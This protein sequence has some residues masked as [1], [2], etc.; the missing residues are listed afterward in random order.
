MC[1]REKNN[2]LHIGEPGVG[3]TAIVYGLARLLNDGPVPKPLCGAKIFSLDIGSLLAG[4]QYRGDFEKRFQKVMDSIACEEKPVVYIDEIHTIV[5]AGAVNGG[6]LDV[7]NLLKPYL[8]AGHIRFIG[9]TTYEEYKK[10]FEKSR[11]LVRR[12]QKGKRSGFWKG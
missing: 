7:S 4:T 2:P 12:F 3:K 8:S 10:H 9:A 5:G 1:R 11:S 6:S